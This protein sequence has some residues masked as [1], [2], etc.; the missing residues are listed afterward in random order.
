VYLIFALINAFA[1]SPVTGADYS[2]RFRSISEADGKDA[3]TDSAVAEES[4]L[5]LAVLQILFDYSVWIRKRQLGLSESDAVLQL[6]LAILDWIP[7][8]SRYSHGDIT[9]GPYKKPYKCMGKAVGPRV[10][11]SNLSQIGQSC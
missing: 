10:L 2:D 4:R 6:I 3:A 9:S 7:I 1:L 5:I 11:P 8:E